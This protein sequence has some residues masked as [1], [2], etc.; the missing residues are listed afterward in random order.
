MLVIIDIEIP[1]D[2]QPY[3]VFCHRVQSDIGQHLS[4]GVKTLA[5]VYPGGGGGGGGYVEFSI[6]LHCLFISTDLLCL[7]CLSQ[8]PG[9]LEAICLGVVK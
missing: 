3:S 9:C 5:I 7:S 4:Y 6:S 2:S 8:G 1:A